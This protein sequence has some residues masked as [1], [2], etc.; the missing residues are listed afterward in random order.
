MGLFD[1]FL[2]KEKKALFQW[3]EFYNLLVD[4][5]LK[6]LAGLFNDKYYHDADE[7]IIQKGEE[8]GLSD[9]VEDFYSFDSFNNAIR[10]FAIV[11]AFIFENVKNKLDLDDDI[12][13]LM[14]ENITISELIKALASISNSMVDSTDFL[15][16]ED[17]ENRRLLLLSKII[18]EI[19]YL[20]KHRQ[21]YRDNSIR[22]TPKYSVWHKESLKQ[23]FLYGSNNNDNAEYELIV[24]RKSGNNTFLTEDESNDYYL[25]EAILE[26]N[27]EL[28]KTVDFESGF[29]NLGLFLDKN[30][31][32]NNPV[33]LS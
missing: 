15:K 18:N 11:G 17:D 12:Y 24:H 14:K 32:L 33:R 10:G 23:Y 8:I 13:K 3:E 30:M 6:L 2:K 9:I 1:V 31:D 27:V 19:I 28:F 25:K 26:I 4:G 29:R 21:V 5:R 7:T 22:S 20:K 16:K